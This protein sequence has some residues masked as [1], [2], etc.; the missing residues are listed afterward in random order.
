MPL[1]LHFILFLLLRMA[2]AAAFVVSASVITE[3][4]G[5]VIG[6][7][8][9]TLPVSAGPS[10]VFLAIDHDAAFIAQGA[11]SSLPVNAA[12]IFMALT[13]VV[14]AQRHDLAVSFGAA[15][16]IWLAMASVIRLFDWTL[17]AGLAVNFIAFGICIPLLAG[18]R[19]VK[20]PLVTRR[21]YDIPMRAVLVATLV[22]IVVSTSGWVGPRISGI[23]ALYPVVFS[24]MM[25]ILHPRIGGPPTA[26]VL[27]N[28]DW[29]L[30][31]FGMAIAVMHV[32]VVQFGSALGLCLALGTCIAWNLTLWAIGR[33]AMRK[34]RHKQ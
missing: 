6:A 22:A 11:L 12:T 24:S 15:V 26:A 9:A 18:Y 2:I 8:V 10:Y 1:D 34:A 25:V 7:L 27:A 21:W 3:R 29:G 31:G 30:L 14:L 32:A 17:A 28:S 16:A 5:P 13:Y 23:I 19:H 20:M 4:S 33:R